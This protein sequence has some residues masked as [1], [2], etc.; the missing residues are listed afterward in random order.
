M[1]KTAQEYKT[2]GILME[3]GEGSEVGL[4]NIQVL[5]K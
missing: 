4:L 1:E 5:L 2:G 3:S